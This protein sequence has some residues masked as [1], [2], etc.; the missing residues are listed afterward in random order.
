MKYTRFMVRRKLNNMYALYAQNTE[1]YN[2]DCVSADFYLILNANDFA[3][4]VAKEQSKEQK[5]FVVA[6]GLS[7]YSIGNYLNGEEYNK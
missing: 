5:C 6:Y 1:T 4:F 3:K 2:W 7:G